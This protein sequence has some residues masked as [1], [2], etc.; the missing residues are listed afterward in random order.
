[1]LKVWQT[2]NNVGIDIIFLNLFLFFFF[3]RIEVPVNMLVF[4]GSKKPRSGELIFIPMEGHIILDILKL[5]KMPPR[6]LISNVKN[7]I[8]HQKIQVLEF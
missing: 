6:L 2:E 1:V 4:L 5:K 7:S 3:L 8:F